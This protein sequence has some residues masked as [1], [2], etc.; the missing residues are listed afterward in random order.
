MMQ[1]F[2][3]KDFFKRYGIFLAM[4]VVIFGILIYSII[5]SQRSW[6][7]SLKKSVE[8]VLEEKEPNTWTVENNI[9]LKNPFA[10]NGACYEVRNRKTGDIYKSVILRIQTFYGPI[11]AVFLLDNEDKVAFVGYSSLHGVIANQLINNPTSKRIEYWIHK[12]PT[13][14]NSDLQSNKVEE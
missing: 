6:T 12:I 2:S 14:V 4:L 1:N 3:Y 10:M 8:V 11:P 7:Q 13:I 5:F 9:K